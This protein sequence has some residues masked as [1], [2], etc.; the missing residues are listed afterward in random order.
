[1]PEKKDS[2]LIASPLISCNHVCA[3]LKEKGLPYDSV[4]L[5]IG[6]IINHIDKITCLND[7]QKQKVRQAF[8]DYMVLLRKKDKT[9]VDRL[10]REFLA[11]ID[12]MKNAEMARSLKIE[13][14]FNAELINAI[15]KNL[16][17]L[18]S[19]IGRNDACGMIDSLKAETLNSIRSA[20][21]RGDIL[22][23]VEAGF[24]DV[25]SR[26][27]TAQEK[28]ELSMES[29]LVL[30]SNAIIDKLTG[31]FNR[32]FFDQELPKVVQTFLDKEGKVPFSLLL[33]DIDKFKEVNDTYGHFIGDRVL[34]RVASIIQ[35]NCRA[36]IDSPIRL[37]GDEFALFLIGTNEKNA[38]KKGDIIRNEIC[39]KPMTFT[40]RETDAAPHDVSFTTEVS[41][42]VCELDIAWK[43]IAPGDLNTNAIFC[44][45][46]EDNPMYKLTCMLAES[47]DQ[48]LYEAKALGRNQVRAY[49]KR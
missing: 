35:N 30:E 37:G 15:S 4:W 14:D 7:E 24:N 31:I 21:N 29:L 47:A 28:M 45:P 42:G 23:I 32:R 6:H 22:K 48:A 20:K 18:Y 26:V 5:Q 10:G 36:G 49:R 25:N 33:I 11:E 44:D 9:E 41:I 13:Q 12:R 46:A 16:H 43:D 3:A 38:L 34:Q 17:Q 19:I 27:K 2:I 1:M 39:R 40:Q 8:D